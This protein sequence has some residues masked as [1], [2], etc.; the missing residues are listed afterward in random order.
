MSSVSSVV[1][2]LFGVRDETMPTRAE[3]VRLDSD[4][5][6]PSEATSNQHSQPADTPQHPASTEVSDRV[7]ACP[8]GVCEL[9]AR[10]R[11]QRP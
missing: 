11:C 4:P 9:P 6:D 8:T 5:A 7:V 1:Q 3:T 10:P 2:L